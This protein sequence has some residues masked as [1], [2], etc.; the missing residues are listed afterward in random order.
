MRP[1]ADYYS[2]AQLRVDAATLYRVAAIYDADGHKGAADKA[3][4]RAAEKDR[5]ANET[6]AAREEGT[7]DFARAV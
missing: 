5:I 3:R 6:E 4:E 1:Q 7:P 2:P